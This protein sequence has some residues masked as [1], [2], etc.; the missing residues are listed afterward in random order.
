MGRRLPAVTLLWR[1]QGKD[2][3]ARREQIEALEYPD[4]DIVDV[5]PHE[6]WTKGILEI[7]P[8]TEICIFLAD[9]GKPIGKDFVEQMTRPLIAG[10]DLR[11]IMHFWAGN[12]MSIPKH[13]LDASP[14]EDDQPGVHS[15]LR[16]LI[17]TLDV[18][19]K[20]PNGR[21]HVAFSSTERLA[22]MCMDPVGFP[23]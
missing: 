2:A 14:I 19:E 15:L 17:P 12:A 3:A 9:D 16:L 20:Q 22:P 18:V 23:S 8:E 10:K 1:Y 21:V 5:G 4:F 13:M 11:A 7:S 6:T